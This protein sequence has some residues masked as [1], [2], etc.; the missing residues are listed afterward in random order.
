V[1]ALAQAVDGAVTSA[2]AA[3]DQGKVSQA[4]VDTIEAFAAAIANTGKGVDAELRSSDAWALQKTKILQAVTNA[5]LG[6]LKGRISPGSQLFISSLV[7]L[8][9][10]ISSAVGGPVL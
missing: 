9:N 7:L 3:R 2:I 8:V 6:T 10:Q 1:N 5:S 4:D